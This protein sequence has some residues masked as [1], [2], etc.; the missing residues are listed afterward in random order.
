MSKHGPDTC[1]TACIVT[2][3]WTLFTIMIKFTNGEEVSTMFIIT[4]LATNLCAVS[5]SSDLFRLKAD[6]IKMNVFFI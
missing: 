6:K 3:M 2:I 4:F 5:R 1:S